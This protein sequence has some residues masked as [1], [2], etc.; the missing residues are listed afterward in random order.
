MNISLRLARTVLAC[1]RLRVSPLLALFLQ[2][3]SAVFLGGCQ[4][5]TYLL[6][7]TQIPN[8][9]NP[10]CTVLPDLVSLAFA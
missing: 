3:R 8:R 9:G 6:V 7:Y 5:L 4:P 2:A 10:P 1:K